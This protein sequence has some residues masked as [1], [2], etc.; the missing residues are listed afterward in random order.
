MG[1]FVVGFRVHIMRATNKTRKIA[2]RIREC[3]RGDR[4]DRHSFNTSTGTVRTPKGETVFYEERGIQAVLD[5]I[6]KL[7]AELDPA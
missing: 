3:F 7:L 1:L 2:N 6:N 5:D 4:L